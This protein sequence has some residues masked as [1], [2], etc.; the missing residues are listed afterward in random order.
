MTLAVF[1]NQS[2]RHLSNEMLKESVRIF[3][4]YITILL[5]HVAEA[6]SKKALAPK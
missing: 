1:R 3:A 5:T 6:F 4:P 2:E